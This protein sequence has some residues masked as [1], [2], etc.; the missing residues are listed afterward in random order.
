[1]K[2]NMNARMTIIEF[3]AGLK[4]LQINIQLADGQLKINAPK[5]T[6]TPVLLNELKERKEELID[7]LKSTQTHVKSDYASIEPVEK[8]DYYILSPAQ[9]RIY[10][11]QQME[12]DSTGY[13]MPMVIPL[14]EELDKQRLETAFNELIDRH[15]SLRTSFTIIEDEPVQR[16]YDNVDFRLDDIDSG[17]AGDIIKNLVRP[18]DLSRA[19]L[20]RVALIR[21]DSSRPVLFVDTHH[22]MN[23]GVSHS[24]LARELMELYTGRELPTLRL[25]YKDY[26]EWQN[27]KAQQDQVKQQ[28]LY[29]QERFSGEL[30]VLNLPTDYPRP[31]V[32]SFEGNSVKFVLAEKETRGLKNIASEIDGTLYMVIISVFTIFLSRLSGQEDIIMG[33]PTAGRRHADL[34]NIIGMF[35]NT[36]ALRNYPCGW[37]RFN[38]F[39]QEAKESTLG[40]FEN[41]EY[42]FEK[43]V[44]KASV[45]RDPGRNPVFDVM[46]ALQNMAKETVSVEDDHSYVEES[47]VAKFDLTLS[48]VETGDSMA[49]ELSYCIR[50]FKAETIE[51]FTVYFKN[52]V[53]SILEDPSRLISDIE[54]LNETEKRQL[55]VEF[56]D[57]GGP[58]P[59]DKTIPQLFAEQA[60]RIPEHIAL[61]GATTVETLR[62]TS[63][64]ITYHELSEQSGRLAGL[65]QEKGVEPGVKVGIMVE[66]SLEMIIGILGILKSGGAYLPIDPSAPLER[67]EYMLNDSGA[68]I[69]LGMEECL[70]K[71]IVNCQLLIVNCK[72]LMSL[73]QAPFHH[74][75]FIIHHSSHLAYIIYTSG[76]TGKP[77]GV[78]ITHANLSPLLHWGYRH[79]RLGAKDRFLQNL[80]Y[81]FDWSVWEI[82]IALTTGSS[83]YMVPK[84]LL[85]NPEACVA[86]MTRNDI[87]V[88]HVTPTQYQYYL[89]AP[90]R[91]WT[92]KYLFIGAEKLSRELAQQSIE[93]VRED[94]RVFNMYGPTECTIISAV[95]EIGRA[96]VEKFEYLSSVPIG[97]A[98]GNIDLLIL[99]KYLNLSPVNVL[100][101]LYIAGDCVAQGYLNNPELTAKKFSHFHH[102]SFDLPRIHHSKLYCTGDLARRLPDGNVEFLGRID[103]QV[104]IRGFRIELG[105]IES[106][107]LKHELIKE[108]VVIDIERETGE[109]YLCAYI[110]EKEKFDLAALKEYLSKSLPDYMIPSYF[111]GITAIPLNPNGKLDRRALPA[112]EAQARSQAGEAYAAPATEIEQRLVALW[113]EVLDINKD[114]IGMTANFFELGGH[115]LKATILGAKIHKAFDV[116]IPLVEIFRLPTVRE[117]AQYIENRLVSAEDK[118]AAVEPVEKKEYYVLSS[119]QRRLYILQQMVPHGVVYNMPQVQPLSATVDKEKL[120]AIFKQLIRRHESLRTSFIAVNEVPVQ[121]IHDE[122][123]FEI[124]YYDL[125]AKNVKGR[126]EG[127]GDLAWLP[128][129]RPFDLSR[130]PL[131]RVQL[132]KMGEEKYTL[133]VDMHHIISDGFSQVILVKEFMSIYEGT[134]PGAL[135]PLRIHYRDFAEWQNSNLQ[136][137]VLKR[138][139]Q[140]WL[141]RLAGTLPV[142]NLPYDY[143]RPEV[144]S[145]EGS[146]KS[147]YIGPGET[148]AIKAMAAGEDATFYMVLLTLFYLMLSRLGGQEDIIV[149]TAVAGRSH[150]DLQPIIGMFVNTLATRNYPSGEKS[151][152]VFL[153]EVKAS[154]L[155]SF[156]NQDYQF[157]DLVEKVEAVRNVGRNPLFDVVFTLQNLSE[158]NE[159]KTGAE[160]IG[161]V[162]PTLYDYESRTAKFDLTLFA[163]ETGDG[164]VFTLEYCTRL[165]KEETIERFIGYFKNI[166]NSIVENPSKRIS[167]VEMLTETEKRQL[168]VEFNDTGETYPNDKTIPQLFAEQ[169][170]RTPDHIAVV[171]ATAVQTLRA[172]SLQI[173]YRE[174]HEQSGRLAGLLQ[175]KGV[176]PGVIVGIKVERS[177]EMIIGILGILKSG[178]AYLPIDPSAP[179]ERIDYMLKD[180]GAKILLGME[181]C[182]KKIIVNCKLLMSL[183]QASFH[184]SSFIIHHS[185]HHAYIIYTSGST[186]K[187][188]GAPISYANLSPLLHWG[189]RHLGLGAKDRFLQNLSYYFDWS[190]WE[191]FIALTTGASLYMAAK[192]LLLNP[193]VCVAFMTRND[194]TV[195]HVTPT[196]YQYYLKAPERPRTLKYLFIGAEK[197]SRELAQRSIESVQEDCRV[198]NMYGPTECTI[199]SAVLEIGRSDVEKF[200]NLSG[201][202][203]GR[204]V[205]NIDLLILDRYLN[206]SPVNV[207]GELYIAG[208]CVAQGYLNNPELTAK[209]FVHF[210][211]SSFDLPRI[212]HS[213]LYC[214]GDLARRLPDGNVEFLGRI[215]QQVKI[216][217]FRI[218]LGEIESEL[219]KYGLVKEAIV[220]D[221]ESETGEKYL[222]GYIVPEEKFE[223]PVLKEFVSKNL[224]DYMVPSYFVEIESIPL[225]PNGKCDRGALPEP[226]RGEAVE[227]IMSPRNVVEMML[228]DL[229]AEVLEI[230]KNSIGIDSDFFQLGGH[231][232]K[233]TVLMSKINREFTVHVPLVQVFNT[234]TIRGLAGYLKEVGH[235]TAVTEDPQLVRL[236]KGSG[237]DPGHLFLVH[238]GSGEV[239]GYVE[240]CRRLEPDIDCWGIRAEKFAGYAPCNLN[241]EAMAQAYIEKIK[242]LQ[243]Q[244]PYR[245]AGW[246]LGGTIAF[247]MAYQLETMGETVSFLGLIDSPAP[248]T[249]PTFLKEEIFTAESELARLRDYL[250]GEPIAERLKR[251]PDINKTWREVIAFLEENHTPVEKV[252]QL[253]PAYLAQIIPGYE[254]LGL[255]ELIYYLN[256]GRSLDRARSLYIPGGK[257]Y[258]ELHHFTAVDSKEILKESWAEYCHSAIKVY[259]LSGNHYSILKMPGAVQSAQIFSGALSA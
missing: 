249:V 202:P 87:T 73:P 42:P 27:S 17:S 247:E 54:M 198:F 59:N 111:M 21:I 184:H 146:Q 176:E 239:E 133:L 225:N 183:P 37:K 143:P 7:F 147:F 40:A 83:L 14:T 258:T 50:L 150:A 220:I 207:L 127:R 253:I 112:L 140:Y 34:E 35:V 45:K 240:F 106:E 6:L 242:T 2:M 64:Q 46:F 236:K 248:A 91:P 227:N 136:G 185:S 197:L 251:I 20:L 250:P 39:L 167:D 1:M 256:L 181:E 88:L 94:C 25:Q 70:K 226:G 113:A 52:M 122:V 204:A 244:G 56:N 10:I 178:G 169:A 120:T 221:R 179:Q 98:V 228:A 237:A 60:E 241:I 74:S 148:S 4:K 96:D 205:G 208:D 155:E 72:L 57:T 259:Q 163:V 116:K 9:K 5:G 195:L 214:T 153:R 190:V 129:I 252:R 38:D 41:Q 145:F 15:E 154:T 230:E 3:I 209:K 213:K 99:D 257:I 126:E 110:V 79:L 77:K 212:H 75:S 61:V 232:L 201:V 188:K 62:A 144:Q 160:T 90:E 199:I 189:Y 187:P 151:V 223:L 243:P 130:A 206:L 191:I 245:I 218:E 157:E 12:A 100:G 63:L 217:G 203:I 47:N 235:E 58:Y 31:V 210:H 180:S 246:S 159:A 86:F 19:P 114:K 66:R 84:E 219:M 103:Q 33:T 211:H 26:A 186:G 200:E 85:L 156:E 36:L 161:E 193:E 68:K 80:S 128:F 76:S 28:E 138:Q 132:I 105:E 137:E 51:R 196:Q 192:E 224:P 123:E 115:S 29:W 131:L 255:R 11:L 238:D 16:I 170:E 44:E 109:P 177:L 121:K 139:E 125:A 78:P 43:L 162:E 172:A 234:P 101:E 175:E 166:I 222:C 13:N 231:S 8:K 164:F 254:R 55:L 135:T 142:L 165:F 53:C 82:F 97:T 30:P 149:G 65:L 158:V 194:I 95:L 93:S 23:D 119:A 49:F 24:I 108:A 22:I 117:S 233:A 102:S 89:K 168:L 48:A 32:Q 182:L 141:D 67:I 118:Y 107:L 124:E 171:G 216:R 152:T 69:L 71:I 174:L 229:W 134:P 215:D 81:Y 173:T 104:K 18:F 92:L